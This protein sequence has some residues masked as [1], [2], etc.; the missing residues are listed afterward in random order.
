VARNSF[1]SAASSLRQQQ[2]RGAVTDLP[3]GAEAVP[4]HLAAGLPN[5]VLSF[6]CVPPPHSAATAAAD[7]LPLWSRPLNIREDQEAQ[8]FVVVP[9]VPPEEA[10]ED[11]AGGKAADGGDA[12]HLT[13]HQGGAAFTSVAI[14]RLSVH[15]RAPGAMH[16][17]LES[18]A[19]EPPYLLENRTPVPL[20]YRQ[21]VAVCH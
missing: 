13:A 3:S 17:V 5:H 11:K 1:C 21:V 18:M 6:R 7:A 19:A 20:Q 15:R 16:I 14:L 12:A 10:T 2:Q 9:V 8:L 4:L